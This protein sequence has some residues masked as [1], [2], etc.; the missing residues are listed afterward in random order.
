MKDREEYRRALLTECA[1]VFGPL[2][3]LQLR[4]VLYWRQIKSDEK[5]TDAQ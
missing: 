3:A 4:A 1:A 2:A 5:E